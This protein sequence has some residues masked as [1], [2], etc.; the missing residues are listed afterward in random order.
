MMDLKLVSWSSFLKGFAIH[1]DTFLNF[2]H[3]VLLSSAHSYGLMEAERKES[4]WGCRRGTGGYGRGKGERYVRR[5]VKGRGMV[6]MY[7]C[8]CIG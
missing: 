5:R 2:E 3:A 6:L 7:I 8:I 4:V 1:V